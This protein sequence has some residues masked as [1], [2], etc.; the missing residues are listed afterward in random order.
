MIASINMPADR[1]S[2]RLDAHDLY[3]VDGGLYC[4]PAAGHFAGVSLLR[5]PVATGR[6]KIWFSHDQ[7]RTAATWRI[8]ARHDRGRRT[9]GEAWLI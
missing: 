4:C 5:S 6:G 9:A 8:P 1:S 3:A 7:V 2:S